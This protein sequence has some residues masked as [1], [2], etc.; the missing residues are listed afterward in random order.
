MSL[1]HRRFS[2]EPTCCAHAMIAMVSCTANVS[3]CFQSQQSRASIIDKEIILSCKLLQSIWFMPE[4]GMRCVFAHFRA[5]RRKTLPIEKVIFNPNANWLHNTARRCLG[6]AMSALL[7]PSFTRDDTSRLSN[8][9]PSMPPLQWQLIVL[10]IISV[11]PF[12]T[13]TYTFNAP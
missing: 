11:L 5:I 1:I 7:I 6:T 2:H 13:I 9:Q 4:H 10:L 3:F 12:N 8:V